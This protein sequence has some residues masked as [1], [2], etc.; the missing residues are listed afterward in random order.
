[1]TDPSTD[2]FA[3]LRKVPLFAE[4][5]D[6]AL[7]HVAECATEFEAAEGHVLVQPNRPGAGLFVIE[8]GSVTVELPDRK[9]ELGPGE[10]F[11][12]LALLDEGAT[13]SARVCA[14]SQVRCLALGRDDFDGLL[15]SQPRLA[16]A[17]LKAVARRLAGT[18]TR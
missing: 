9:I 10:F 6:D 13:H 12:E 7:R 2:Q 3:N 15:D 1:M 5:S 11:G 17:M 16:V 14:A 18:A 4:L 8:E